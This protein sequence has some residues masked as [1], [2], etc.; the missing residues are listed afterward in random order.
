MDNY[1]TATPSLSASPSNL[2]IIIV[3]RF[4]DD[5]VDDDVLVFHCDHRSGHHISS[6]KCDKDS[7]GIL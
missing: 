6:F 1:Y 3:D 5:V 7:V 4:E 2:S